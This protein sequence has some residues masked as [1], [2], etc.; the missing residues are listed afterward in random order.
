MKIGS[1][2]IKYDKN[3]YIKGTFS[4]VGPSEAEG[5]L[6]EYY[7]LR[8]KKDALDQESYEKAESI[9]HLMAIQ[10]ACKSINML[11][12]DL[13]VV[14]AGDLENQIT[15]STFAARKINTSFMGLYGA[16]ATFGQALTVAA[17]MI[18][19]GNAN[20]VS[21][22]TSSH[23]STAERQYRYPLELGTAMTPTSQRTV[24]ASGASI[25]SYEGENCPV[26]TYAT[27][28]KVI[29]YGLKNANNM[30]AA[31][32]PAAAD[33]FL[34]HLSETGRD[35]DYYDLILTGDLGK[36]GMQLFS[37][38]LEEKGI[39]LSNYGDS[40]AMIFGDD[41]TKVMGGSGAGCINAVFNSYVIKKMREK[42]LNK[43]LLVPTGALMSK[44]SPLQKQNIPAQAYCVAI[45]NLKESA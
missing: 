18:D 30:G 34:A 39:K 22:S 27:I 25:L 13:D 14:L 40:G 38:L 29:D 3:V 42:S 31:M 33:S 6:C 17:M 45:E 37:D 10:N 32:A 12:D 20:T 2:T 16:C 24:T 4:I 26:I 21:C 41:K 8:I 11:P 23:F 5:P 1:Q 28:G 44:D 35:A 15:A 43:V 36:F 19:S 7:D 9:M